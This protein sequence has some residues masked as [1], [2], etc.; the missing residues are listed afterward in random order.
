MNQSALIQVQNHTG[1]QSKSL[2]EPSEIPQRNQ[3]DCLPQRP[4]TN[5][6]KHRS[7]NANSNVLGRQKRRKCL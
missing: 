1:H 7:V 2:T 5:A 3:K 4:V 6:P